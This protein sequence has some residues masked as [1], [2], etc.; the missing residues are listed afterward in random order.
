MNEILDD[1]PHRRLEFVAFMPA[2]GGCDGEWVCPEKPIEPGAM[3]RAEWRALH[4]EDGLKR[5]ALADGYWEQTEGEVNKAVGDLSKGGLGRIAERLNDRLEGWTF[6]DGC[7]VELKSGSAPM[8]VCASLRGRDGREYVQVTY[9]CG[10][11]ECQVYD[12]LPVGEVR[13]RAEG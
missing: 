12:L 1:I 6:E 9:W 7:V 11:N 4:Y 10:A 2:V 13:R 3:F 8:T 5:A